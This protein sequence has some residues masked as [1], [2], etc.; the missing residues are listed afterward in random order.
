MHMRH[1]VRLQCRRQGVTATLDH[2]ATVV[3]A[4]HRGNHRCQRAR[5]LR[6]AFGQH[7]CRTVVAERAQHRLQAR[8]ISELLV[9]RR[10][11]ARIA[12]DHQHG[13]AGLQQCADYTLADGTGAAENQDFGGQNPIHGT[14]PPKSGIVPIRRSRSPLCEARCK[15]PPRC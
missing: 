5:A 11:A 9:Q 1:Q 13:A 2:A 7:A 8:L 6:H 14:F 4:A 12:A 15:A 3:R 10:Q